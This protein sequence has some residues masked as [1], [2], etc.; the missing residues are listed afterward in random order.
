MLQFGQ[1]HCSVASQ[2]VRQVKLW[3]AVT[4]SV[5]TTLFERV[6]LGLAVSSE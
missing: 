3:N 5:K 1:S 6:L 4:N 2:T